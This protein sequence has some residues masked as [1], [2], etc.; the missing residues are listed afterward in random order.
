LLI[1][2]LLDL[3]DFMSILF[4]KFA[5]NIDISEIIWKFQILAVY[6]NVSFSSENKIKLSLLQSFILNLLF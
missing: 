6:A 1:L 5:Y 3:L 4:R 2:I